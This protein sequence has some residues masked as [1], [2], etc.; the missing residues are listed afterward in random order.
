MVKKCFV[1]LSMVPPWKVAPEVVLSCFHRQSHV[2]VDP[3]HPQITNNKDH[4]QE[5]DGNT[6]KGEEK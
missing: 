3:D 1:H 6:Y 2:A 5:H 4:V